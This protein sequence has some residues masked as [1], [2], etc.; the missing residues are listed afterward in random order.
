[1]GDIPVN[2]F[3]IKKKKE[4]YIIDPGYEK[5]RI[6]KYIND[7]GYK[8][9]GILL[10]HAHI[11]H[12]EALHCFDVPVYL[13]EKEREILFDNIKNGF[14]F[15]GKHMAYNLDDLT[16]QTISK[17]TVFNVGNDTISVI[18][19]PGHTIGS[20]CY[21]IGHDIYT[22]DTLFESGVGRWDRPTAN[23]SQLK[24]SVVNLI[25]QHPDYMLIHP[26]HGQSSTIGTEKR[27]NYYYRSW[28]NTHTN[29]FN[30]T[31]TYL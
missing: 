12:I 14:N 29:I 21:K 17:D 19:T 15:F 10:T 20:V 28:S 22:G 27:M 24:K 13:H 23:L 31:P 4:G 6:R 26:A 8:I 9:K 1:M 2:C 18:H 25:E 11:D 16:I 30:E 7:R 3:F 5:D